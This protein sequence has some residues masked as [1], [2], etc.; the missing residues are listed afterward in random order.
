MEKEVDFFVV[1]LI[2]RFIQPLKV[3]FTFLFYFNV[4]GGKKKVQNLLNLK[5]LGTYYGTR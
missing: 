4:M 2:K 1:A 3:Y 5:D